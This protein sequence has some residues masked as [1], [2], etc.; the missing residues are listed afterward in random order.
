MIIACPE[1]AGPFELRDNDVAALVQLACPHCKFQMILDFAAANDSS[2]VE[3]GMRMASGYRSAADYRRA[4]SP[5]V[6]VAEVAQAPAE[7]AAPVEAPRPAA[8]PVRAPSPPTTVPVAPPASTQPAVA[9]PVAASIAIDDDFDDASETIVR[10]PSSPSATTVPLG[11]PGGPRST[12]I[13]MVPPA[14][15]P[16][17]ARA[18]ADAET[19]P[20]RPRA[21]A[22]AAAGVPVA[23]PD[24]RD[25]PIGTP[26]PREPAR[27]EAPARTEAPARAPATSRPVEDRPRPAATPSRVPVAPP[28]VAADLE[29]DERPSSGVFGTIVLVVLLLAAVGLTV[30]S[31]LQKNT[32]DPRPLLEDLYRQYIKP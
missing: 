12:V 7:V 31:V 29:P 23:I 22:L 11:P 27:A 32:L 6:H 9:P 5:E 2:L 4:A 25:E 15:R 10:T 8:E 21:E 18:A 13:G 17:A 3:T 20:A 14:Q 28:P 16:P 26:P 1:C 19:E 30:V 24:E